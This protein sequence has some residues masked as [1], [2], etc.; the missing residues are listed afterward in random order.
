LAA[1]RYRDFRTVV[2]DNGSTDDTLPWL[3]EN[4]PEVE[5]VPLPRNVGVTAALNVCLRASD[6]EF[7]ALLN[8]DVEL[9]PDVLGELVRALEQDRG[10][11]SAAAKLIDFNDR[12]IIDGA[13][14][15][16]SWTGEATRTGKGSA[17]TEAFSLPREVFGACGGA[18]LY[19]SSALEEV[20]EFDEQFF[21]MLEDVDWSF[22]AQLLGYGCR[23][24]P[25]AIVYHMGSATIGAG[26]SDFTLLHTWRNAIWTV[27]KD[28]PA[29][30]LA[31]H[32]HT[33]LI[34]Q[35]RTL[36]WAVQEGRLRVFLTA[37]AQALRGLPAILR[38]RRDVQRR[39]RAGLSRLERVIGQEA[40]DAGTR[41]A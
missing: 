6:S 10:A 2:V 9:E 8:N 39:R 31:R 15:S 20:G 37:W 40:P 27:A 26:L 36:I 14:D 13:G 34:S 11:A 18:A 33:V 19:R 5:V 41:A 21:A 22:R 24:V 29:A 3:A 12:A 17:D 32:G 38:K 1:Q 25:S 28:Y 4:W 23:Y 30:A 7:V 16:Y 35:A